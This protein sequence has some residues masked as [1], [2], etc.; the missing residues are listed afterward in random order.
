MSQITIRPMPVKPPPESVPL[1]PASLH[2]RPPSLDDAHLCVHSSTNRG[3]SIMA[4]PQA[5]TGTVAVS[6][7][8]DYPMPRFE[9]TEERERAINRWFVASIIIVAS[10]GF[11]IA[12]PARKAAVSPA[13]STLSGPGSDVSVSVERYSSFDSYFLQLR[14]LPVEENDEAMIVR[15]V[16]N[17]DPQGG[18][19]VADS[20]ESQVRRLSAG[21]HLLDYFGR[22]GDGPR[23][24]R[25]LSSVVR[26][27]NGELLTTE[28]SGRLSLMDASGT[29]VL[30]SG[31]VPIEPV[32]AATV[33]DDS[34]VILTGRS[35]GNLVHLWDP[36]QWK[37]RRSFYPVPEH[38]AGLEDAYSYTGWPA[39][40]VRGDRIAVLFSLSDELRFFRKD[41]TELE[42]MRIQ[43]PYRH[44]RKIRGGGPSNSSPEAF[45]TWSESF[46]VGS[47]IYW[48][49]DDSFVIQ[50]FDRSGNEQN[51]SVLHVDR[52]G[53]ALFEGR[54]PKLLAVLRRSAD[55]PHLLFEAAENEE[56]NRWRIATFRLSSR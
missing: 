54:T 46:S 45:R 1:T 47:R 32:W 22:P 55:R 28:M 35:G 15:P 43:L 17:E 56:P 5:P 26:L 49:R 48:L 38:A 4:A 20:R 16:V 40:S 25:S 33:L 36:Y 31:Q 3:E 41:G 18:L 12:A 2:E 29:E 9:V 42:S 13:L 50:Y 27:P 39:V 52:Q 19:L 8:G 51:W 53:R 6:H 30:R 21:G 10:T 44:F 37:I 14:P 24:F 11:A 34:T 7:P 23:E